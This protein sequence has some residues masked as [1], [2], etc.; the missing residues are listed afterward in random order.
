MSA[1]DDWKLAAP[2]EYSSEE[3]AD[4]VDPEACPGCGARPGNG[5]T[6]GCGHE[7]G[8]GFWRTWRAEAEA[9]GGER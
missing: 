7:L 4:S 5:L 2:P 1:Y 8:C 6:E 9:R 3:P